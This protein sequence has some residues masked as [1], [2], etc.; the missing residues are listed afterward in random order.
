MNRASVSKLGF[1]CVGIALLWACQNDKKQGDESGLH[2]TTASI[3]NLPNDQ[4]GATIRK[5]IE[6]AGGW[7]AWTSKKAL[8]YIKIITFYDSTGEVSRISRQLHEYNLHPKFQARI[9]YEEK[10]KNY[11]I[12]NNGEQAWKL[13]DDVIMTDE[14][15]KN[16]SWNS[17]FGS[18]YVM[19]M[20]F[21]L[22][23]SGTQFSFEGV[24]TL[25]NGKEVNNIKVNYK[26]GAGSSALFHTWRYFF[27]PTT[28]ELVA[29]FLD[30]TNGYDY[31][32]YLAF[33]AVDGVKLNQ[34][35]K[36][37]KSDSLRQEI[38]VSSSYV[39]EEIQFVEEFAPSYFEPSK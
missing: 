11:V 16:S 32:E 9:S 13:E 24:T 25:P 26:E 18:H 33:I 39:N 19:C 38:Q 10:G 35:R 5:A 7:E 4:A 17:S 2:L 15:S 31:T 20:P 29:N 30:F 8:S 34:Q 37:Y 12:I 27:D 21:K 3:S 22:A 1:I 23:D 28:N 14:G 36:S 6:G